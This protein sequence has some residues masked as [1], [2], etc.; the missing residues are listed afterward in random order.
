MKVKYDKE[1]DALYIEFKDVQVISQRIDKDIAFDY[2]EKGELAGIEVLSASKR[3][4]FKHIPPEI[5]LENLI[6]VHKNL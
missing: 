2:D 4:S 5:T 1:A 3:F 6:P